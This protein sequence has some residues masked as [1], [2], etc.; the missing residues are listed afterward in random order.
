MASSWEYPLQHSRVPPLPTR[1]PRTDRDRDGRSRATRCGRAP[2]IGSYPQAPGVYRAVRPRSA[3]RP[4]VAHV[5][6][7]D[8][9]ARDSGGCPR[10]AAAL[11]DVLGESRAS[12]SPSLT[13]VD[14]GDVEEPDG[15][16]GEARVAEAVGRAAAVAQTAR[17][18][19]RR[20]LAHVL[21]D[22]GAVAGRRRTGERR[23]HH[24]RRAPRPAR[25]RSPTARR[26]DASSRRACRARTSCRSASPTSRTRPPTRRAHANSAST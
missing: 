2:L 11:L 6:H 22:A 26:C 15:P 17:R 9:R 10:R 14:F 13:A 16:E 1:K 19:G 24:R 21:G 12:T 20:Q 8:G 18:P 23:A 25:R 4:G 7:P 5:D 3:R